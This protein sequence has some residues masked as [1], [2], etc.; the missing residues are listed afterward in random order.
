MNKEKELYKTVISMLKN[1]D[2]YLWKAVTEMQDTDSLNE[3]VMTLMKLRGDLYVDFIR[4]LYNKYPELDETDKGVDNKTVNEINK[5]I[6]G[7]E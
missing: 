5:L 7:K 1:A 2:D 3:Q 6:E 4:P